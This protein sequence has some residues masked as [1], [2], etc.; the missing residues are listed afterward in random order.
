MTQ[1]AKNLTNLAPLTAE[2]DLDFRLYAKYLAFLRRH[3]T[4][5]ARILYGI[6]VPPHESYMLETH[7]LGYR[8]NTLV[9]SRGTSKTFITGSVF[10]Q[11]KATL[12][13]NIST[14]VASASRF[15]GGKNVLKDSERLV[16]GQLRNQKLKGNWVAFASSSARVIKRE[17]DMWTI[18]MK[19]NSSMFTIP[20]NND[21]SVLGL[22]ANIL[23]ID[24]RN[25]FDGQ[26]IQKTYLP[27]L[28]VGTDFE[29]PAMGSE[30]NQVFFIGTIDYTYR[31]WYPQIMA[32]CRLAELQYNRHKA[33]M[34][35]D[36]ETYDRIDQE[37]GTV[38]ADFSLAYT[39]YDYTDLLIPVYIDKYKVHYPGA[40][41]GKSIKWDNR[42]NRHLIFSYPVNKK[43]L[44]GDY[45]K[46]LVDFE[47]WAAEQRNVFIQASGSVYSPKLIE[48][49]TGPIYTIEEERSRG[50][51]MDEQGRRY[52]PPVLYKCSD[53][54]ILG[55]DTARTSDFSAFV[56]IRI[57]EAD[58]A[59]FENKGQYDLKIDCGLS[60]WGNVIW[61]EQ[62]QK[63]TIK[64]ISDTIR[65]L[66]ARYNIIYIPNVPGITIDARGGGT[67]VRDELANP[68]PE[69]LPSGAIDP[70]WKCPQK[71]YDP[72]D[73]EYDHLSLDE[74][75]WPGLE[76]LWTS[77]QINQELV[78][79]SRAQ[80]E[81]S[82][83]YLGQYL[84]VQL[85]NDPDN[86]L[87]VGYRGVQTLKNQLLRI[88]AVPTA[89][90]K[91]IRYQMP[92]DPK[93]LENKKDL[94]SAFLYACY[95]LRKY[96]IE[97]A[98]R[99]PESE[100]VAYGVIIRQRGQHM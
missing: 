88:Q 63:M 31:D 6:I 95:G 25:T 54:C 65:A 42:D 30:G 72:K 89:S 90:G 80:M 1:L 10:P 71:I 39:R 11:I 96:T 15:R 45:D 91:S 28:N 67:N 82:R 52:V 35:Q 44:E 40:L 86:L 66:R 18:E 3:P 16:K 98:Q 76:L 2:T 4:H 38:L 77:D 49:A 99:G 68:M 36:W 87:A 55:V 24:E 97:Y 81:I 19:T 13:G 23:V 33:M 5:A 27:F 79:F 22:R 32:H 7:W 21:E 57:G 46:G 60:T 48:N 9:C 62:H 37:H 56:I 58:P 29:N 47:T 50:W 43:Q 75:N 92:G 93:K 100:P 74:S 51:S 61:A 34:E 94:F 53:P 12:F 69:K 85:R 17:P 41:P 78:G 70:A 83:L 59:M 84:S 14:L 73:E 20:T 26:A 8:E 64:E